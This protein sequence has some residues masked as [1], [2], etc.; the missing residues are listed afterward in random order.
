MS[1]MLARSHKILFCLL[2]SFTSTLC[3]LKISLRIE[4]KSTK[5]FGEIISAD[6]ITNIGWKVDLEATDATQVPDYEIKIKYN[7]ENK[8]KSYIGENKGNHTLKLDD[9]QFIN[10]CA[11]SSDR[12][13]FVI[14]FDFKSK[15]E[16]NDLS[17][18]AKEV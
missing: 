5:C 13:E 3:R 10:I 4:P 11:I 6:E 16:I 7:N 15:E 12:N 2:L 17:H 8:E 18:I 9:S 1:E 14:S